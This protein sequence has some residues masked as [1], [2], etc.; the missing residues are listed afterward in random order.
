MG[1]KTIE[2]YFVK[3]IIEIVLD[4]NSFV[5]EQSKAHLANKFATRHVILYL[6]PLLYN[7]LSMCLIFTTELSELAKK[8]IIS[9]NKY[10]RWKIFFFFYH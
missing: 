6:K 2:V 4:G 8:Q 9:K 3:R 10:L 7:A 1:V 5:A